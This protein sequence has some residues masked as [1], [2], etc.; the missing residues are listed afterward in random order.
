FDNRIPYEWCHSPLEQLLDKNGV[1]H[2]GIINAPA[3]LIL[4]ILSALLI[5][6]T[7]ESASVNTIIVIIKVAIVLVFIAIG[8]QFIR[9]ENHTPYFI[10][11][12][13]PPVVDSAGKVLVDYSNIFRHGWGGV[14]GGAAIVFFAFI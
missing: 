5:K 10:P 4:L 8:W 14:L 7:K 3:L 9:P 12:N 2:T 6:G 1:M 13:T 11:A